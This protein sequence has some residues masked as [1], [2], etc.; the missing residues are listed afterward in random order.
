MFVASATVLSQ[1]QDQKKMFIEPKVG[2]AIA[3]LIGSETAY[4]DQR[5]IDYSSKTAV[6]FGI[7]LRRQVGDKLYLKS[8]INFSKLGTKFGDNLSKFE[9]SF[10]RVPAI[11]GVS[12]KNNTF[13]FESGVSYNLLNS[14]T[15]LG[16]RGITK[17]TTWSLLLG[18][19]IRQQLKNKDWIWVS[20]RFFTDLSDYY[21]TEN[22]NGISTGRS[23]SFRGLE[24]TIGLS[25]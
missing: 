23:L 4:F 24:L 3:N 11:L 22:A 5:G 10:F 1:E 19:V 18:I 21:A 14:V 6:A 17:T 12:N 13:S 7:D 16:P 25:I 15:I 20:P 8:G 2:I 9:A